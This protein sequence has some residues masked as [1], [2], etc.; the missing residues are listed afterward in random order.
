MPLAELV[1]KEAIRLRPPVPVLPRAAVKDTHLCGHHIPRGIFVVILVGANHRIDDVWPEPTTF[2]P[3]R[4]QMSARDAGRHRMAW[5][6]YGGG[7]H[8]CIGMNFARMEVLTVL[9]RMLR[10]FEWHVP[11]DFSMPGKD[12]SLTVNTGFPATIR[13]RRSDHPAGYGSR[14]VA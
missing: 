11:P 4:F 1:M 14:Q 9:H 3:T 5:M 6:P 12:S 10:E 2:D 8:K 7:V 13:R